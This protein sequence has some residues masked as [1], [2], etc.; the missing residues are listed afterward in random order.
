MN[1]LAIFTR[2]AGLLTL[3]ALCGAAQAGEPDDAKRLASGRS[4]FRCDLRYE[5]AIQADLTRINLRGAY[6]F[7]INLLSARL[8]GA[9][10]E[11][12]NLQMANLERAD[13]SHAKLDRATLTAANFLGATLIGA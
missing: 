5:T 9:Q 1:M 8:V 4:C 11:S 10:M 12:S 2:S 7:N 3:A 6:M 13:L